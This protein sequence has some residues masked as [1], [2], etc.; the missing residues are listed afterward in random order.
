MEIVQ[1]PYHQPHMHELNH[2]L[3]FSLDGFEHQDLFNSSKPVW[4]SF[5]SLETYFDTLVLGTQEGT[6]DE[7]AHLVKPEKIVIG[8]GT[9]IEASA[10]VKGP[11]VI[12]ENCVVRHGAYIR[13]YSIIGDGCVIGHSSEVKSSILLNG[14]KIPHF[15]YVGDSIL[16]LECNLGAGVICANFRLDGGVIDLKW[17]DQKIPTGRTKFGAIVGDRV[18]IGC[19]SVLNPG[20]LLAPG[21]TSLACQSISGVNL[22]SPFGISQEETSL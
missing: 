20:T 19:N 21:F 4:A 16:G 1:N 13:P 15:N 18:V 2:S 3:F 10:Y 5:D 8:K 6:V 12:G 11:C 14:A 22:R 7:G 17:G 9:R